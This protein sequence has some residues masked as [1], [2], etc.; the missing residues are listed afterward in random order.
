MM[1]L[2]VFNIFN[3]RIFLFNRIGKGAI[4]FLPALKFREFATFF[5]PN[6]TGYFYIFNII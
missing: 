3:N 5:H 2:L 4:A 1:I 6:I